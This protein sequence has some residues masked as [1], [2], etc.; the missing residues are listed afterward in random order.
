MSRNL[1]GKKAEE[2]FSTLMVLSTKTSLTFTIM[3]EYF[4]FPGIWWIFTN[5][6]WHFLA[7]NLKD[8]NHFGWEVKTSPGCMEL[9][10]TVLGVELYLY[11]YLKLAKIHLMCILNMVFF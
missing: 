2:K 4:Q 10:L 3:R 1:F 8:R 7:I 6:L 9:C 11:N 5:Q